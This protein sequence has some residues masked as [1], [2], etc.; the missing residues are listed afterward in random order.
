M[1]KSNRIKG[2]EIYEVTFNHNGY[3]IAVRS[4]GAEEATRVARELAVNDLTDP[5]F[6]S[7]RFV[8]TT[9]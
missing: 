8:G 5:V 2:L 1:A 9:D 3:L 4:G 7:C 6:S